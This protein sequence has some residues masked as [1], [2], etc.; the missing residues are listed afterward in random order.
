M[1]EAAS[2]V[3][4]AV[5]ARHPNHVWMVDLPDVRGMFG[6][7]TFKVSVVFDALSRMPLS[8]KVF[9]REPSAVEVA[10]LVSETAKRHGRPSHFVSDQGRCF[11][12]QVF[13]RKL[14]RL[15]VK[16]SFGAIGKKGSI[17]LIERLWRTLAS[18]TGTEWVGVT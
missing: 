15:G 16:Q 8:A 18:A 13:R 5:R 4:R 12:G 1:P 17:A 14:R 9:S 7:V 11:T 10:R 3:P 2:T 6:I